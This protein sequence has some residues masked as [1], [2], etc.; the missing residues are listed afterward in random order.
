VDAV[1][2]RLTLAAVALNCAASM[3]SSG[4]GAKR[5]RKAQK[6]AHTT[7]AVRAA[8]WLWCGGPETAAEVGMTFY[9][10]CK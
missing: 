6:P 7:A 3:G 4:C 5:V 2:T 1:T 8:E 10:K 9:S